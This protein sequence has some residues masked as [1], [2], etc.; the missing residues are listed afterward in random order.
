MISP[1]T[2]VFPTWHNCDL[3]FD[4]CLDSFVA[5]LFELFRSI[6]MTKMS[7]MNVSDLLHIVIYSI[8]L[9]PFP[10]N[11]TWTKWKRCFAVAPK[12]SPGNSGGVC[13]ASSREIMNIRLIIRK[14]KFMDGKT[15]TEWD[16]NQRPKHIWKRHRAEWSCTK[17]F[18]TKKN[19]DEYLLMIFNNK[20]WAH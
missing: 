14:C 7:S 18:R 4:Y 11:L 1:I 15:K 2:Y 3:W 16:L 13:D 20:I 19:P 5:K 17:Y 6:S 12:N 8:E 9:S 10:K